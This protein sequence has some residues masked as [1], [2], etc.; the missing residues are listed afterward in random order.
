MQPIH[1]ICFVE[2][3]CTFLTA[4]K[5]RILTLLNLT[6]MW[7]FSLNATAHCMCQ[8]IHSFR[9]RVLYSFHILRKYFNRRLKKYVLTFH[10]VNQLR[11][12]INRSLAYSILYAVCPSYLCHSSRRMS[13]ILNISNEKFDSWQ[14]MQFLK[15]KKPLVNIKSVSDLREEFYEVIDMVWRLAIEKQCTH[16][17]KL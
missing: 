14:R 3:I 6:E 9:V 10:F 8:D 15:E 5:L 17:Q 12:K 4:H 13:P 1:S 16:F 7:F 2:R 11:W